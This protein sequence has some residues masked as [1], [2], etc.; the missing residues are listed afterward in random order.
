MEYDPDDLPPKETWVERFYWH[1]NRCAEE[2]ARWLRALGLLGLLFVLNDRAHATWKPEFANNPPE[3]Q[4]WYKQQIPT[5]ETLKIYGIGWQSCCNH[6]DVCQDCVV[7]HVS[8]R[9]PWNDGWY[10]TKDGVTKPLPPHIVDYVPWTPTGKPILFIAPFAA[11]KMQIGD[12]VCLKVPG[13]GS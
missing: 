5:P 6:G 10:Y 7:H 8:D 9:P 1:F 11:G 2:W 13:S 4:E 3:V 12:P